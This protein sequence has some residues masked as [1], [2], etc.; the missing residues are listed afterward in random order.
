MRPSRGDRKGQK[1]RARARAKERRKTWLEKNGPCRHCGSWEK[2]EIDHIVANGASSKNKHTSQ[3]MW[4]WPEHKRIEEIKKCQ[5]LCRPC[6]LR[7]SKNDLSKFE[8]GLNL[9]DRHGCRCRVC[10]DANA[11]EK[12]IQRARKKQKR[13]GSG[14]PT[15]TS[16]IQLG[17][18][19]A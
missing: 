18:P 4:W 9:Y 12:R 16:P 13:L 19:L 10:K 17:L 11:L 5:P 14:T 15:K 6:H 3:A 8:H 2:L 1:R 7:K